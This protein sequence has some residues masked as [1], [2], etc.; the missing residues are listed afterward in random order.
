MIAAGFHSEGPPALLDHIAIS[1]LPVVNLSGWS[2]G[3]RLSTRG[4]NPNRGFCAGIDDIPSEEGKHILR[5][6]A[7]FQKSASHGILTSH[8]DILQDRANLYSS[9]PGP[10]ST[11]L[12]DER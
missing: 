6:S 7:F 5:H 3:Q 10:F 12:V 9:S 11:S 8:E 1:I 4:E 2:L